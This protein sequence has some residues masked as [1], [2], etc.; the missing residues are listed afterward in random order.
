MK[1]MLRAT[2]AETSPEADVSQFYLE[3]VALAKRY[4]TRHV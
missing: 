2:G 4:S 1:Y 3:G